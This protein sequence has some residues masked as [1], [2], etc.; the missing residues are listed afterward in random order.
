MQSDLLRRIVAFGSLPLLATIAPVLLLPLIARIAGPQGWVAILA[1]QS[2]G[3]VVALILMWGLAVDGQAEIAKA[4]SA[5]LRDEIYRASLGM[6]TRI[7]AVVLPLGC[8]V[9]HFTT[10]RGSWLAG[11]LMFLATALGGFSLTWVAVGS[12]R[13]SWIAR[14]ELIPKL[15]ATGISAVAL[16]MTNA[17]WL[18]P[19]ILICASVA[20]L[21]RFHYRVFGTAWPMSNDRKVYGLQRNWRAAGVSLAG[22]TYSNAPVPI[23]AALPV[24]GAAGLASA[25]KIFAF[26]IIATS[27]LASA[28]QAWVLDPHINAVRSRNRLALAMHSVFGLAGGVAFALGAP[29]VTTVVFGAD[30]ATTHGVAVC[31][32]IWIFAINISTPLIRNV[33]VPFEGIGV[34]LWACVAGLVVGV[35]AMVV[36]GHEI[37]VVG[38]AAG[39]ALSE[40]VRAGIAVTA[41]LRT[42]SA[43]PR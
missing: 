41:S 39:G 16:V 21:L 7:S 27:A 42:W 9:V 36:L 5:P 40:I 13:A 34:T 18:Y 35:T 1:S 23:A 15:I 8:V 19:F 4:A 28:L 30:V 12:A 24:V 26:S 20:G 31:Y 22:V 38:V 11:D 37:G 25:D 10:A 14:Y 17:L 3:S 43:I 32:G 6:R 29:A 2:V 33:L